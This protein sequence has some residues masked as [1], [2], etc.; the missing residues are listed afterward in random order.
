MTALLALVSAL[1]VGG[2]DFVGGVT[3]RRMSAVRLAGAAQA[4]GLLLALAAALVV[5][6]ETI[7]QA[8]VAWSLASGLS[9]GFGL[10]LF[11]TAM[12]RGL[13]SLVVPVAAAV[14]ALVPV[15]YALLIG[16]RPGPIAAA[17]I[18]IAIAAITL[19]SYAP[20][21][22]AKTPV[23]LDRAL[24]AGVLF[25]LFFV[26]FARI[27]ADAGL[28]PVALS[29]A[30]SAATLV[31]LALVLTA[32]VTLPRSAWKPTFAIA[33]LEVAA[34]CA[35]LLALQRGPVSTASVLAALYPVTTTFL[36]TALLKERLAPTQLVGV[37]LALGAVVLISL[38]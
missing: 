35:L 2:A 1:L 23:G 30:A 3:S 28:W 5:P 12:A 37:V 9:L 6:Y 36:A 33:A 15:G 13:I 26:F 32:G 10:V 16:E 34:A 27:D 31:V 22:G 21:D 20:E 14:G 17:G 7:T 4:A 18:V 11:Y 24:G 19:V 38:G 25:G 8:D 29:R